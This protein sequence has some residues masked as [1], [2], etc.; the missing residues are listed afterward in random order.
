MVSCL[1]TA[2][3][4]EQYLQ[5]ICWSEFGFQPNPPLGDFDSNQ[6]CQNMQAGDPATG[7]ASGYFFTKGVGS[8]CCYDP[9]YGACCVGN[10]I[11]GITF[12]QTACD[13]MGGD[14]WYEYRRECPVNGACCAGDVFVGITEEEA[15][16]GEDGQGGQGSDW[17][18]GLNECPQPPSVTTT[19]PDALTTESPTT[20]PP[21]T[22]EPP[23]T[24]EPPST[25]P[26][27]S[28]QGPSTT[29]L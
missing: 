2:G 9:R 17:Y 8:E 19:T 14:V 7:L 4:R 21:S 13:N 15:C 10:T 12:T 16:L 1:R 27:P 20:E 18:E 5:F 23:P 26:P 6:G 29:I 28:T 11:L 3:L 25:Q 24:T 22:T